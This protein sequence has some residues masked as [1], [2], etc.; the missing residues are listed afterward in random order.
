M[1]KGKKI[2]VLLITMIFSIINIGVV[3]ADTKNIEVT[4]ITV[5]D[6]SG[7]ITVIDPVLSSNEITSNIT[8]NKVDDFVTFELKIKNN[9]SEK[10]KIESITDNNTNE[11]ITIE[12]SFSEDYIKTNE[13][14]TVTIKLTYKNKLINVEKINLN[15]I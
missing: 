3:K 1:K 12:Y 4:N 9:E 10:Y 6:K 8:F 14:S 2:I 7:T 15:M 11:N 13:T 5:K